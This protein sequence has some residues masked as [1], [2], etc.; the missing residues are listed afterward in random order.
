MRRWRSVSFAV[1][2]TILFSMVAMP[3]NGA[4]ASEELSVTAWLD[5]SATAPGV[6]CSVDMSIELRSDG[7]SVG[8]AEVYIAFIIDGEIL[9]ADRGVTDESGIVYLGVDTSGAYDGAF[10]WIDVLV[11]GGYFTGFPVYPSDNGGCYDGAEL[12]TEQGNVWYEQVAATA[13]AEE[14]TTN[15]SA[16]FPTYVQ[17]RNLSCEYASIQIA[18]AAWGDAISEYSL[19]NI[20]GWSANPHWG[21]RGDISGWWGNTYDYGVYA[22]AL[23]AA[24]PTF[25]YYGNVFYGQGDSSQLTAELDQGIPTLVWLGLWGDQSTFEESDGATYKLVAGDH[26]VVAYDYDQGGV[27]VSDPAVGAI[28]YYAWGD[29]MYMWNVFDGMAL[30]VSPG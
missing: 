24:L 1:L 22:E 8:D 28:R 6:G 26:V 14:A 12:L 21:F 11:S 30:A 10:G 9:S 4:K 18:T 15:Y 23:A 16:G 19:D 27:Y 20:V 13:S 2:A 3:A 17:Q 5:V 7:D 29:F 25:G